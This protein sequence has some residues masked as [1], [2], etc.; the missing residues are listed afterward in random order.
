MAIRSV[1]PL[2]TGIA[3]VLAFLAGVVDAVGFAM[4]GGLFV[5]FMSGNSTRLGVFLAEGDLAKVTQVMGLIACF[6]IGAGTGSA[7]TRST[8]R[9]RQFSVLTIEAGLLVIAAFVSG[10]DHRA[11]ATSLMAA[12]M[13]LENA[14]F[15]DARGETKINLTFMTGALVRLGEGLAGALFGGPLWGWL[16][17]LLL[18]LGLTSGAVVGTLGYQAWG[19][20]V[21]YG[22]AGAVATTALVLHLT[23]PAPAASAPGAA[24]E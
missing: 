13:G 9:W 10:L 1:P 14:T 11:I 3:V 18:W 12:A 23:T 22:V 15:V 20:I 21:L 5:S 8:R 6:V 7:L 2:L 24:E 19:G 16:R 17:Y 4:L